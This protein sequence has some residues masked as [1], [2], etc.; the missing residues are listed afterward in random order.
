MTI[1]T[2]MKRKL[3]YIIGMALS[4]VAC[5]TESSNNG[6][7]DGM[8]QLRHVDTL[9]TGHSRDMQQSY[10]VWAFEGTILEVRIADSSMPSYDIIF[11][12]SREGDSLKLHSPFFSDRAHGDIKVE[13]A[14]ELSKFGINELEEGFKM[15]ELSSERMQLQ[16]NILRLQFRKY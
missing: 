10:V 8:W 9:S 6:D 4:F 11:R 15:T 16:S 7:L 14:D 1:V 5:E 3:I 13:N 2:T 12:F